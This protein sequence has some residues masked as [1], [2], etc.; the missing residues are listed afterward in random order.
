MSLL[1]WLK[2]W[3]QP[4]HGSSS[5]K[6]IQDEDDLD[7]ALREL[8]WYISERKVIK[9]E[10]I[11]WK[12]SSAFKTTFP[13]LDLLLTKARILE[14]EIDD[15]PYRIYTWDTKT[16]ATCGWLCRMEKN[17]ETSLHL[18]D[19]HLLLTNELGGLEE[20]WDEFDELESTDGYSI[21]MSFMFT[22]SRCSTGIGSFE[23]PYLI[24]CEQEGFDLMPSYKNLIN[25]AKQGNGDRTTY[26]PETGNLLLLLH[27][28]DLEYVSPYPEQPED[29]FYTI[30]GILHF[31]EYVE[32]LANQWRF[33]IK[34]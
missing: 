3:L 26:H 33:I 1:N 17:V 31:S 4:N 20:T 12:A 23:E 22:I 8:A 9:G 21:A 30:K 13:K 18:I 5:E 14:L 2:R 19:E 6:E 7:I 28:T 11:N 15:Y 29:S 34:D 10:T 24:A 27:D 32:N 25:F 16:D